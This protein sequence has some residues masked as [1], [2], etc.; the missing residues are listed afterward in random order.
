MTKSIY[1]EFGKRTDNAVLIGVTGPMRTGKSTFVKRFMEQLVIPNIS[2]PYRAE[3]AKDELP[4]SASGRTI[5]TSE[6]KFVPEE[7]V[8]ISPDGVSKLSVRL[9]DSVGYM[10]PGVLGA[11]EDGQPRLVTTPWFEHEIP[12]TQA[13]EL[14]TKK[15]MEDHCTVGVVVTT[16]GTVTDLERQDYEEAEAR[17]IADMQATGKPFVVLVNT[18]APTGDSALQLCRQLQKNHG[19]TVLAVDCQIMEEAQIRCILS[20]VLQEFPV[21]ELQFYMPEWVSQLDISHPVK[22]ALYEAMRQS[23]EHIGRICEAEPSIKEFLRTDSLEGCSIQQADLGTGTVV[24]KLHFPETLFFEILSQSTGFQVEN[25]GQ[26]M[27]LMHELAQIKQDYEKVQAALEQVQATGYGIVMPRPEEM[28]LETPQIVKKGSNYALKLKASAP[29]IH[30]IRTDIQTEVNPIVGDEKQSKELADSLLSAYDED[31][32]KVWSSNI[33]GKSLY[34]MVTEGLS[35]KILGVP[36]D[37]RYKFRD[38]LNKIVNEGGKGM[39][40]IVW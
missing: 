22:K 36:E 3:R 14:G 11:E 27:A 13:A 29:S 32:E 28:S 40:C 33:F 25:D 6:P 30:M 37:S 9:I 17:A 21:T 34:D 8:E 19:V 24:C 31:R 38:S 2:D 5:M 23:A 1:E 35:G 18:K 10:V 20:A 7:A 26:L 15:V 39:V 16:D 12:L 4:Q